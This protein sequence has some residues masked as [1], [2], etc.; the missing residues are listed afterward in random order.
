[1]KLPPNSFHF[2][3]LRSGQPIVWMTRSSGF[4]TSHTSLTPSSQRTG[5]EP[6]RSKYSSAAWVRWP[7]V[8]SAS[9]VVLA[10]TSEPGS[11]L[12]SSQPSLPR[13]RSPERI[14]RTMRSETRSLSATVSVRMYAPFSSAFSAR[15]RD[16]FETEIT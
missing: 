7:S 15:N 2:A 1:M 9:T 6:C 4:S 3:R 13:P 16:S 8:P 12:P 14:P 5:S 10:T 11:K